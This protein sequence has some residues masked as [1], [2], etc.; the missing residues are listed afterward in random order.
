VL[1]FK[2]EH[3]DYN[4]ILVESFA[5][6]LAEAFAERPAPGG[7]HHHLGVCRR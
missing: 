2:A 6:R 7:S 4:A 5:D 3:D 1:A